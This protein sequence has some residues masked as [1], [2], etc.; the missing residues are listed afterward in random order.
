M[1]AREEQSAAEN[2]VSGMIRSGRVGIGSDRG[3]HEI[4]R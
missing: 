1:D 4:I 2:K 3:F